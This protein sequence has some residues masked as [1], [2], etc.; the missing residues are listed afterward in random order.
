LSTISEISFEE[1]LKI[2]IRV[3]RIIEVEQI[4]QAKKIL[5][6]SIDIGGI[7]KQ[8]IAGLADN[9][10]PDELKNKLTVVIT[11]LKPRKVFGFLSE[12]MIL[13]ALNGTEVAML[14]PDKSIQSGSKIS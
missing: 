14:Q 6:L 5:K 2:D 4:P 9:Y 12:V 3:G 8:S 1:F 11:N 10:S 13:A 7:T